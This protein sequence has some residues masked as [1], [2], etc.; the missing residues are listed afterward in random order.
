MFIDGCSSKQTAKTGGTCSGLR[1]VL[2]GPQED[3]WR[4]IA[5]SLIKG[6]WR[7]GLSREDHLPPPFSI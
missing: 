5:I 6:V 4:N 1:K 3:G 7:E 2:A